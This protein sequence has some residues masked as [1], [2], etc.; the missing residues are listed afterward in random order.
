ML[1]KAFGDALRVSTP[2]L[3]VSAVAAR[4]FRE[5]VMEKLLCV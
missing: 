3:T 4:E 5:L 1:Q 2:K